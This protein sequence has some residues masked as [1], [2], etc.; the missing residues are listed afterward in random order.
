MD[1]NEFY[2]NI[3]CEE[4]NRIHETEGITFP[5]NNGHILYPE[6]EREED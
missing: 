4:L 5:I 6:V 2:D 1:I 3:P